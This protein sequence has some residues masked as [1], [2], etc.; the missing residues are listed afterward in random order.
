MNQ[1]EE[2]RGTSHG[3]RLSAL[4]SQMGAVLLRA[5][6]INGRREAI[7]V[8][9]AAAEVCWVAPVFLALVS[10]RNPHAPILLWLGLLILMLGY[11][12]FYRALVAADL[13]LRLQQGLLVAGLLLSIGL[14]LRFH[15]LAALQGSEDWLVS[16]RSLGDAGAVMRSGW[17]A[18]MILV[19]LWARGIHLANRSVSAESV[20][21]SF[22]AGVVILIAVSFSIRL[23]T[24]LDVSGFVVPYFFFA[25]VAVALARIEDVKLLPDSDSRRGLAAAPFGGFWIG[26]TVA[27]VAVLVLLG[28]VMAAFFSGGGL[29][30]VLKWLSPL[31]IAVLIV[32]V[33][34]ATVLLVVVNWI[35]DLLSVDLSGLSQRLQEVMKQ[36]GRLLTLQPLAPPTGSETAIWPFLLDL[37]KAT[38]AIGIPL[39]LVLLVLLWTWRRLRHGRQTDQTREA[40]ESLLSARAVAS[41]LQ[42][43]VRSGLDRLADLAGV[44]GRFG[45]T[46]RFLAAVSIRHIYANLMRL[47]AEA[48][49]PRPQAQTPYEC[50]GMLHEALPGSEEDVMVITEAYIQAHYGQLPDTLEELRRIRACWERVRAREAERRR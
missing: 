20:G 29:E 39:L 22:R 46:T 30:R 37:L 3:H 14:V 35:F 27:A 17:I 12:A 31:W 11:S 7:H 33:G 42:A 10:R 32:I 8:F 28:M 13:D 41:S 43:M 1:A 9:L 19:Y 50:L 2:G 34:L 16:F 24:R 44:L 15:V 18:V 40:R 47:A 4:A 23:A 48:G 38:V 49:Y 36:L 26:T 25:L 45:P 21:F 6:G 5:R